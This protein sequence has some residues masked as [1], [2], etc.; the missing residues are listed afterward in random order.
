MVNASFKRRSQMVVGIRKCLTAV[1][2]RGDWTLRIGYLLT[3]VAE[4]KV[5]FTSWQEEHQKMMEVLGRIAQADE[6]R[7]FKLRQAVK[8]ALEQMA[9]S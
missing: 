6:E 1:R 7:A 8:A 3:N 2:R 9:T 4:F 5:R